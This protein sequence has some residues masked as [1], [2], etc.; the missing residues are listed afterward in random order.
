MT[1]ALVWLLALVGGAITAFF[2]GQRQQKRKADA[3]LKIRNE[4]AKQK[5]KEASDEVG[6]MSDADVDRRLRE[7]AERQ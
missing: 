2:V 6:R 7:R 4:R 3:D 1:D 5:A